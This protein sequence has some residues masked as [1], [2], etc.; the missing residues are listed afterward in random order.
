M[1]FSAAGAEPAPTG[2]GAGVG[3]AGIVGDPAGALGVLRRRGAP[4]GLVP[5]S[6]HV[7]SVG[8]GGFT[9]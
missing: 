3:G 1:P 9:L 5:V 8:V 2:V 7:R 6:G 4:H